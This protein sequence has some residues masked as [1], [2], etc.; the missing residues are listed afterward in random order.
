MKIC[1]VCKKNIAIIF[2][3]KIENGK[4]ELKGLCMECAKNMGVPV[5]DQLMQQTGYV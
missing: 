4:S 3:S 1:S 5:V 2:T